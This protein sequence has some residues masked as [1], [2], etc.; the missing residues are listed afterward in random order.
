MEECQEII[1]EVLG[2]EIRA[3]IKLKLGSKYSPKEVEDYIFN[4]ESNSGFILG[5]I[6]IIRIIVRY[7]IVWQKRCTGCIYDPLSG[8]G[9]MIGC[10]IGKVVS[11]GVRKKT[12]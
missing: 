3:T 4:F 6:K 10:L 5:E 12:C 9:Y 2:E 11:Y 7:D 1:D 8:N